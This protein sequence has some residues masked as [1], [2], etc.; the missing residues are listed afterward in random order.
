MTLRRVFTLVRG[1]RVLSLEPPPPAWEEGGQMID[2]IVCRW[3]E[4]VVVVSRFALL[5]LGVF[6]WN[7]ATAHADAGGDA[8]TPDGASEREPPADPPQVKRGRRIAG[9]T[10][11]AVGVADLV[12]AITLS[13]IHI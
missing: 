3:Y 1:R 7:T 13:L 2:L 10:L 11:A 6:A 9:V 12:A 5:M 8:S 4:R